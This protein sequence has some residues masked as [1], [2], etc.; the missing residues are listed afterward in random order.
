MSRCVANLSYVDKRMRELGGVKCMYLL[1]N[2]CVWLTFNS[3]IFV[4]QQNRMSH[5]KKIM[6]LKNRGDKTLLECRTWLVPITGAAGAKSLFKN[7]TEVLW[8]RVLHDGVWL[9]KKSQNIVSS[10]MRVVYIFIRLF[11]GFF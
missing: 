11:K 2:S 10:N 4:S 6:T 3:Q 9:W 1:T 5:K 7:D 8:H